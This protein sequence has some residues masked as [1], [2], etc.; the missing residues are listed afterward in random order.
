MSIVTPGPRAEITPL[1]RF[2]ACGPA[3]FHLL[4]F[5]VIA[6]AILTAILIGQHSAAAALP[7]ANPYTLQ[8]DLYRLY[9]TDRAN[10]VMLGDSLTYHVDWRELLGRA[11]VVSRA[12]PGDSTVGVLKRI[13]EVIALHPRIVVVLL[14]INDL[15]GGRDAPE[16][17]ADYQRIL[18]T[19][20][21]QRITP[22]IITTAPVSASHPQ[23]A[24]FNPQIERLNAALSA[25]AAAQH[26]TV[27]DLHAALIAHPEWLAEDGLHFR[28][29]VYAFWR[30][31]LEAVID[32]RTPGECSYWRHC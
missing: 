15:I 3:R 30:D 8:T 19:L 10:I 2:S 22:I 31:A 13:D 1:K 25:Y 4:L 20:I 24:T 18:D 32:R 16:I 17:A 11:D 21:A 14:G 26:I 28:A 29:V 5:I 23:A 27:I 6:S 7:P 9:K 12:I